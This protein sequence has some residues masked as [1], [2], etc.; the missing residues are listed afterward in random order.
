MI[1]SKYIITMRHHS[2][3]VL[4]LFVKAF[5]WF[6]GGS[7]LVVCESG[8]RLPIAASLADAFIRTV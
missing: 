3:C 5:F 7:S 4:L 2:E 6:E 8:P 1:D